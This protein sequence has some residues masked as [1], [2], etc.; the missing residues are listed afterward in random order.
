MKD[1]YAPHKFT[2]DVTD[3]KLNLTFQAENRWSASVAAIVI[4]PE[5]IKAEAETWLTTVESR[6]RNEFITRAVCLGPREKP[7]SVPPAAVEKGYWLGYPDLD[8]KVTFVD[9][10]GKSDGKLARAAARGQPVSYTFAIRPLKEVTGSVSLSCSPLT[11][12]GGTIAP[13]NIELRYVHYNAKRGF[14]EI[15]YEIEPDSLRNVKGSNLKLKKDFTRQFWIA[16]NIPKSAAAGS[17]TGQITLAAGDLK[18]KVPIALEVLPFDVPTPDFPMGFYGLYVP[19]E[20]PA[21]QRQEKQRELFTMMVNAGMTAPSGGPPIKLSGFDEN[22]KPQLDFRACDEYFRA[23]KEAGFGNEALEYGGPG[24]VAGLHDD[25]TIGNAGQKWMKQLNKPFGEVLKVVYGA[26]KEHADKEGWPR[27]SLSFIDEP[28]VLEQAQAQ[29]ELLK[30]Y[31]NSVPW[32]RTGGYYSVHWDKTDPLNQTIQEIFKTMVW[33][34]LNVHSQADLDKARE[35]GR[36]VYIY[37][38]GRDRFSFGA[39]QW[40]EMRKGVK[41][42]AQWHTLALHGYQYFDLDGREP[43][44]AMINWGKNEIIPMVNF[45]RSREG[46]FDFRFACLLTRLAEAKK[47]SPEGKAALEFLDKVNKDIRVGE[48]LRPKDFMTD[49]M[50]RNTCIEHIKKLQ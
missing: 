25:G 24:G 43:D 30:E 16:V 5:E 39:Y 47:E 21:E 41:G 22:G 18:V 38:Q 20:Y 37:N 8:T 15:A 1:L 31:Q 40:A 49:D 4:Y 14:S 50:F 28:R 42:R 11:S 17:Y 9:E 46:A 19:G 10:P 45:Y 29:L 6:N 36:E 2:V 48:R 35:F 3:G 23:A 44:S 13:E 32:V 26:V 33:S 7:L 34:G 12:Q 27:I